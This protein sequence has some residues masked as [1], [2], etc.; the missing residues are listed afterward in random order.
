[1]DRLKNVAVVLV[2]CLVAGVGL[3]FKQRGQDEKIREATGEV[4]MNQLATARIKFQDALKRATAE[5][6][7]DRYLSA[8]LI[9]YREPTGTRFRR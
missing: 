3:R 9:L 8:A 2:M 5:W 1:M 6:K 4:S 7:A